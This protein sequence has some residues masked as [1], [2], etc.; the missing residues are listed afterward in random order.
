MNRARADGG[1]RGARRAD[2]GDL[3]QAGH[4][5]LVNFTAAVAAAPGDLPRPFVQLSSLFFTR[6]TPTDTDLTFAEQLSRPIPSP[7][8]YPVFIISVGNY[9][10]LVHAEDG[11]SIPLNRAGNTYT[12]RTFGVGKVRNGPPRD[13]HIGAGLVISPDTR[14]LK[15][16]IVRATETSRYYCDSCFSRMAVRLSGLWI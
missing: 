8:L 14:L 6:R 9:T 7:P 11:S 15:G 3:N 1:A 12:M 2:I 10:L 4:Y 5:F 13:T 16:S